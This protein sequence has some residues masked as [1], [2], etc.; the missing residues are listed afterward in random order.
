VAPDGVGP[1]GEYQR[2]LGRGDDRDQDRRVT[3]VLDL[4]ALRGMSFEYPDQAFFG[5]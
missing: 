1:D 5:I 3:G 4:D 2:R